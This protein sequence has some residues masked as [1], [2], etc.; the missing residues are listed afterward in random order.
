MSTTSPETAVGDPWLLACREVGRRA[1][2]EFRANTDPARTGGAD[3]LVAIASASGVRTRV[4]ALR[5]G[6]WS[7]DVGPMIGR[8]ESNG[9]PVA[10]LPVSPR[11]YRLYDPLTGSHTP[12][13]ESVAASLQ[14]FAW[15]FYRPLPPRAVTGLDL[16]RFGLRGLGRDLATVAMTGLAAGAL[17]TAL[18]VL[19]GILFDAVIPR[20]DTGQV[21]VLTV[22]MAVA[23]VGASMFQVAQSFA[24][25][26]LE[27]KIDAS[28][29]PAVWDRLLALPVPFFRRYAAGDLATRSLSITAMRQVLTGAAIS[30]VLAG[31]FS[32]FTFGLLFYYSGILAFLAACFALV[33]VLVTVFT[34]YVQVGLERETIAIGGRL[35]GML[36]QFVNGISKLRVAAAEERAF[37]AWASAFS[38][39][40][41][42][43]ARARRVSIAY[44]V[45]TSVA[46]VLSAA[47]VYWA[48][49][50]L[51]NA[52]GE[53]QLSTGG[54][55][56]FNV[57]FAQF[58]MAALGLGSAVVRLL[59]LVPLYERAQPILSAVP[60]VDVG[61]PDPGVLTGAIDVLNVNFRYAPGAPLVLRDITMHIPAG[62]FVAIVGPSGSGKS[63]LFR[64][65]MGFEAPDSGEV[66]YDGRSQSAL[67]IKA[68]RRQIGVVL[69]SG[70]LLADSLYKN[71]AGASAYLTLDDA[72][73]AA[74]MAGLERDIENM[75]M[76]MHTLLGEGGSGLSGG[77]RQRVLI[78][79]AIVRKPSLLL[80]D[81][82]TS[83][84]DNETQALVSHSLE[85]L[86]A[87]R[88]VIAH[89]LS[90]IV[91]ADYIYVLDRGVIVQQGTYQDLMRQEGPFADLA[92]RQTA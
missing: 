46:P 34:G 8:R 92:R 3:P 51:L 86:K 74:K 57:A 66:K 22:L 68:V 77:Q 18:P 64:L 83:A 62:R 73:T 23:A 42:I 1:G 50:R 91:H 75:P 60:E 85:S 15:C 88:V 56:A 11:R 45:F 49:V 10:L 40:K 5:E 31:V 13:T 84:L 24:V 82:A 12:L 43:A 87:T 27:G 38:R 79:R 90:T 2:I 53:S 26:R 55:V 6:W 32:I 4:V 28:L 19:T 17:A 52:H 35:S 33:M 16:L 9:N 70:R 20:A 21:R 59:A 69:Q 81:E 47:V 14:P 39:K 65:L 89:R 54:F 44:A 7:E 61:R 76:G 63:T 80:F 41:Q 29:Q 36:L 37:T 71:I 48:T 25:R 72:W 58:Q 78:A 67:D 30:T